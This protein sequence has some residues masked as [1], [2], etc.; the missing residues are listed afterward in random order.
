MKHAVEKAIEELR[1]TFPSAAVSIEE[2]GDGGAYVTLDPVL[3]GEPYAQAETWVGFHIG[4]QYP[5]SDVYP[6]F[7]RYDL[8]R[9]DGAALGVGMSKAVQY[10]SRA[11]TQISRRSNNLDPAHQTAAHKLLKVLTWM[12]SQ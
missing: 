3:L 2:D 4:F 11:A 1:K 5:A 9:R 7:M 12:Q 6:H 8:S 10:R